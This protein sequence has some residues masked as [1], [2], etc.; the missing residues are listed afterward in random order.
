[1]GWTCPYSGESFAGAIPTVSH[2]RMWI[3]T[4]AADLLD[5][6]EPLSPVA[7]NKRQSA[8]RRGDSTFNHLLQIRTVAAL[9]TVL[10]QP[11]ECA[12]ETNLRDLPAGVGQDSAVGSDVPTV[13]FQVVLVKECSDRP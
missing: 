12:N 13:V 11:A 10:Q 5:N 3:P 6:W 9:T 8:R 7:Y 4:L 1:M 2:D